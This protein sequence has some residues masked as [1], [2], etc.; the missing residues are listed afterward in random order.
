MGAAELLPWRTPCPVVLFCVFLK[1]CSDLLNPVTKWKC[2]FFRRLNM[3]WPAIIGSPTLLH[4]IIDRLA[5][6]LSNAAEASKSVKIPG[7]KD[8]LDRSQKRSTLFNTALLHVWPGIAYCDLF[9]AEY[10]V[11]CCISRCPQIA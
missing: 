4:V 10:V 3:K 8:C 9:R 5:I 6:T 2:M 7:V 11:A 1:L